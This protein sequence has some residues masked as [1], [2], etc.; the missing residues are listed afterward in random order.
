MSWVSEQLAQQGVHL[1]IHSFFLVL[2][3]SVGANMQVCTAQWEKYQVDLTAQTE[4]CFKFPGAKSDPLVV[5]A[6]AV[7]N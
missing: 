7:Q 5:S 2:L 6:K 3:H 1:L 4:G